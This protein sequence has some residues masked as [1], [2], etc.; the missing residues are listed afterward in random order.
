MAEGYLKHKELPITVK[1]RGFMSS[2]D[3]VSENSVSVMQEIGIDISSHRSKAV[4]HADL[5]ADKIICMSHSHAAEL[6]NAG[7][8]PQRVSILGGG[9]P[10]PFGCDIKAYRLCRDSIIG[11]IDNLID[12]GFFNDFTLSEML[13]E[14]IPEVARLEKVCFSEP[15]SENSILE[16]LN[17]GTLFYVAKAEGKVCGYIG[18]S[19]IAGEGYITNIAVFPEHRKRGIGTALL[20]HVIS[21]RREMQLDFVSLEVRVS[22]GDAVSIYKKNGFVAEGLRKNFYR[23]PPEDAV[24][25]TRRF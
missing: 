7:A 11:A 1:S 5:L 23:N 3:K 8:N 2:G 16:S 22:N 18:I 20:R 9:I 24:I 6:I 21:L 19:I 10:D 14:D 25:M 17:A 13:K 15:W 12:N 4:S